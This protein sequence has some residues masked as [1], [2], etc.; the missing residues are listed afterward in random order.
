M[1]IGHAS[2][3]YTTTCLV[4]A[5]KKARRHHRPVRAPSPGYSTD[6]NYGTADIPKKPYPK[7]QRRKQM[8]DHAKSRKKGDNSDDSLRITE[9]S[10]CDNLDQALRELHLNLNLSVSF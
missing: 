9:T 3:S 2:V 10:L 8:T 6:S 5:A 4:S 1:Q 7:S